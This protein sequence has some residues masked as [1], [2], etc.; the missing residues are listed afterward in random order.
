MSNVK[1][2]VGLVEKHGLE[3]VP[4]NERN[5]KPI[6]M[7]IVV[8]GIWVCVPV[9]TLAGLFVPALGPGKAILAAVIGCFLGMLFPYFGSLM[10]ATHGV[11]GTSLS[12]TAF[13]IK[14]SSITSILTL[15][16]GIGW[17]IA[18][19]LMAALIFNTAVQPL[20][21][22]D[23]LPFWVTVVSIV[24]II[25][26]LL[27]IKTIVW[28]NRIFVPLLLVAIT[29]SFILSM[30]K[31][32]WVLPS[33]EPTGGMSFPLAVSINFSVFVMS[34]IFAADYNR[35]ASPEKKHTTS[36]MSA[37]SP[38]FIQIF[39]I[40]VGVYLFVAT[41]QVDLTQQLVSLNLLFLA[42]FIAVMASW[43]TNVTNLYAGGLALSNMI[44]KL[45]QFW[46][47]I[48]V[49]A[50]GTILTVL[51][52]ISLGYFGFLFSFLGVVGAGFVA[53]NAII[54]VDWIMRKRNVDVPALFDN[55]SNSKYWYTA[56][57]NPIA[58]VSWLI[59]SV[60]SYFLPH[61]TYPLI[62][63]FLL[64]GLIYVVFTK[65]FSKPISSDSNV[66]IAN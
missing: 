35:Y 8:G 34:F 43:T 33:Y 65:V 21:G 39:F 22:F 66:E 61:N 3:Q 19:V 9:L 7:L 56:G 17:Y 30:N 1:Q 50:L 6:D 62:L 42:G 55:S 58:L 23:S 40:I 54:I 51:V 28:L 64:T 36:I 31:V 46:S 16:A 53:C 38:F 41:G 63:G 14:G 59:G 44:P 5:R 29:A 10:G 57:L 12:R 25:N 4:L 45:N 32:N 37:I 11:P 47:T 26:T 52:S 13:G 48:I 20:T 18:H 49:G 60:T 27:G 24:C 2:S 15:M